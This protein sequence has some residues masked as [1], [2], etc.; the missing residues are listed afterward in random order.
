M[1][2]LSRI[3]LVIALVCATLGYLFFRESSSPCSSNFGRDS[4][5]LFSPDR[6]YVV[7][8]IVRPVEAGNRLFL[9]KATD[10][11]GVLLSIYLRSVDVLWAE[12]SKAFALNDWG[13]SNFADAYL[14]RCDRGRFDLK[15]L[16]LR[17]A[18]LSSGLDAE[19]NRLISNDDHNY[20]FVEKWEDANRLVVRA[21]GHF[22]EAPDSVEYTR[23]FR[24][25]LNSGSFECLSRSAEE[26]L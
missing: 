1:K 13:G 15:P 9:R 19:S 21:T 23:I 16:D 5:K 12:D 6:A 10:S 25:H 2:A 22:Y 4:V 17:E 20:V 3:A 26:T 8:N 14:Y 18:L 24:Y 7:E 11:K